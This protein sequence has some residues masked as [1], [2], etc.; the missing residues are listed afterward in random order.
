MAAISWAMV[1]AVPRWDTRIVV[2]VRV[3]TRIE[4]AVVIERGTLV[5]GPTH[6]PGGGI[7]GAD[8]ERAIAP[9]ILGRRSGRVRKVLG[10]GLHRRD[11]HRTART[12]IARSKPGRGRPLPITGST[13]APGATPRDQDKEKTCRQDT[14]HA[15]WLSIHASRRPQ[16]GHPCHHFAGLMGILGDC[17]GAMG[18]GG[19]IIGES[20]AII[21]ERTDRADRGPVRA[22]C[23]RRLGRCP[24]PGDRERPARDS[25]GH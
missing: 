19:M 13:I 10:V 11:D 3:G 1:G 23:V 20:R 14:D 24:S 15:L 22:G 5:L 4:G 18:V 7:I 12:G 21:F 17:S 16:L 8:V 9:I 6:P 25:R 2:S